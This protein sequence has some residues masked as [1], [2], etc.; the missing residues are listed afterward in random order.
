MLVRLDVRKEEEKLWRGKLA[1]DQRVGR[2]SGRRK[3]RTGQ[4]LM[5]EDSVLFVSE[6]RDAL[7]TCV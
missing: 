3:H 1:C 2:D 7:S 5:C 4:G 6:R